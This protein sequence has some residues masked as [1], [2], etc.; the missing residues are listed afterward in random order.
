MIGQSVQSCSGT[1][2]VCFYLPTTEL[3]S[4]RHQ[5]DTHTLF[6]NGSDIATGT[7]T[8]LAAASSPAPSGTLAPVGN[9]A[10]FNA[11]APGDYTAFYYN[12][13]RVAETGDDI[14]WSI[15]LEDDDGLSSRT[16][17]ASTIVPPVELT[18]SGNDVLT[19]ST[20]ENTT[21]LTASVDEGTIS[22]CVW[23]AASNGVVT[24]TSG[25]QNTSTATVTA[26]SGGVSTVTVNAALADGR[27]VTQQKTVRVLSLEYGSSSPQDF[28]KGQNGI[29]PEVVALGF[30]STPTYTWGIGN[31]SVATINSTT[32][33]INALTKGSTTVTVSASHGGKI[34]SAETTIYVHEVTVSGGNQID[35]FVGGSNTT[36]GVTIT[37]PSGRSAPTFNSPE[38]NSTGTAA[39][40]Q[41]G[42]FGL[43]R[44]IVPTESGSSTVTC[45]VNLNG[46]N[47]T[48]ASVTVNVYKIEIDVTPPTSRNTNTANGGTNPYALTNLSD[49]FTFAV[50]T[51]SQFPTGTKFHW[52]VNDISLTG[53]TQKGSSVSITPVAMG[54]TSDVIAKVKTSPTSFDVLCRVELP[55]GTQSQDVPKTIKVYKLTIP[56]MKITLVTPPSLPTDLSGAYYV[57]TSDTT[58]TFKFK[59]EPVTSGSSIPDGVSYTWKVGTTTTRNV[60]TGREI[61]PSISTLRNSTGVPTGSETLSLTCEVSL[62][63][64]NTVT[65]TPTTINFAAPKT[66]DTSITSGI[67]DVTTTLPP[68]Q[69]SAGPTEF[70]V[71][72]AEDWPK[73]FTIGLANDV[74]IPSGCT[75]SWSISCGSGTLTGTGRR[76]TLTPAQFTGQSSY[77]EPMGTTNH[78]LSYTISA[79]GYQTV[80][81]SINIVLRGS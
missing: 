5:N 14:N 11:T 40:I 54:L 52:T 44:T 17:T 25:P 31:N 10:S 6:I 51:A 75:I 24:V 55:S 66:F 7:A 57:G 4:T 32:G 64:C 13:G 36:L 8:E 60:G 2:Y 37:P 56:A 21:T 34:V 26:S 28:L 80:T 79:P 53:A 70:A 27:V 38:W 47:I 65:T 15:R 48:L 78:S 68:G 72:S 19:L 30:P 49:P 58:K 9:N 41:S 76:F 59:A 42:G 62:T 16:V 29:C 50:K 35:L 81:G 77:P 45:V 69:Y 33:A 23:T 18:V 74:I 20:G 43:S 3:G 12:T 67:T 61:T 22:S 63:G 46:M 1:Y 71:L 39:V 73:S